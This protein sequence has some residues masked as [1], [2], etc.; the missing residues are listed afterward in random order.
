[1]YSTCT[2][3][4]F[5][6]TVGDHRHKWWVYSWVWGNLCCCSTGSWLCSPG[7]RGK[8]STFIQLSA[9]GFSWKD[10]FTISEIW[11]FWNVWHKDKKVVLQ[12][13][14]G[15]NWFSSTFFLCHLHVHPGATQ[16][17]QIRIPPS[18]NV[19]HID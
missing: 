11:K 17:L 1:M 3:K 10:G 7:P 2:L 6:C 8:V 15:P 5:L 14:A 16:Q 13:S 9:S 4:T 12:I 18:Y 19:I